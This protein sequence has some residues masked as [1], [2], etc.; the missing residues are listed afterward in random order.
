MSYNIHSCVG[1]DKHI[2]HRRIAKVIARYSPDFVALQE[3][4]FMKKR[5]D[6]IDQA[7]LIAE[8]LNMEYHYQPSLE[9]NGEKYGIAFLTHFPFE[10]IKA[11]ILPGMQHKRKIEPRSAIWIKVDLQDKY[12]NI[13]STHL[14]LR[15][16][17]RRIQTDTLLGGKWLGRINGEPVAICGDFNTTPWSK[18]YK[19]IADKYPDVQKITSGKVSRTFPSRWPLVRIDHVFISHHIEL[20]A[21]KVPKTKLTRIASDHLPIIVDIKL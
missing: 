21:V 16:K 10:K 18:L 7:K 1:T 8:D 13:I 19:N 9:H 17:E 12:L 14:G 2:S 11:E 20:K 3:V 4:D 6:K 15:K 5:S